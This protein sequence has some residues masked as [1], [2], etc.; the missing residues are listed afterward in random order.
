MRVLLKDGEKR[1][2]C[3]SMDGLNEECGVAAVW[4]S[5]QQE[6]PSRFDDAARSVFYALFSLQHRGQE[7]AGIAVSNGRHIRVFKKIGLIANVFSERDIESLQGFAAIG[8]T[9]YSTTGANSSPNIQPFF[10]E[11]KYGP[12][13]LAHN[14]NLVN[15]PSLRKKLLERG[16]GLSSTSDTEVM[17]MMLAAAEGGTWEERIA[18]CMEEWEGAFSIVLLTREALY[19]ARDPWGFKP[20]CFGKLQEGIWT[21]ASETCAMLTLGCE[22]F[23]EIEAGRIVKFSEEG[24]CVLPGIEERKKGASC[25]FEYVYFARPDTVWN[26]ASVHSTRVNSGRALARYAPVSADAVIAIPDSSR[27]AAIG[28]AQE[29][30]IKYDEGFSKNRYIGRTFIQPTQKL[31]QQGVAMKFNI[32]E[33]TVKGK[34]LVV[35]DDSIVRGTT[36]GHLIKMLR[37]AGASEVHIRIACPPVRFPCYMGVDMGAKENLIAYEKSEAEIAKIIGADSLAYLPLEEMLSSVKK[38]GACCGFCTACFD[39]NYPVDVSEAAL[40]EDFE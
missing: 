25:I 16:V 40:K 15:A 32:L 28:Y 2:S 6:K 12:I 3:P 26:K 14:G 21:V 39:G 35:V 17:V 30:G 33:E 10:I 31:R 18:R 38:A 37:A 27:S 23:T 7:A 1:E 4:D 19:A 8:H 20:L 5:T 29:S 9:R 34:R 24:F 22:E 13:A 11:T 36:I